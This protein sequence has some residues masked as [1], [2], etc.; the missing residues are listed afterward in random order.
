MVAIAD[1]S[2]GTSLYTILGGS[3]M[4]TINNLITTVYVNSNG[5]M[6]EKEWDNGNQKFHTFEFRGVVKGE[7][8]EMKWARVSVSSYDGINLY[9]EGR[10]SDGVM[11]SKMM[12]DAVIVEKY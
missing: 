12:M 10:R 6:Y 7:Y 9:F 4:N 2:P 3:T 8:K 11:D 5:R 1:E